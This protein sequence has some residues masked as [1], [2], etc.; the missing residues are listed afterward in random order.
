MTLNETGG[1]YFVGPSKPELLASAWRG[2]A[3]CRP[4]L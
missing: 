1:A 3:C 4:G 2:T